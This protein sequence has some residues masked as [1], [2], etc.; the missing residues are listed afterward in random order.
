MESIETLNQRL[1]TFYGH[2]DDG[3]VKFRL[4]WSDDQIEM[5]EEVYEKYAGN[6]YLGTQFGV[7]EVPKYAYMPYQW[8]L[9]HLIPIPQINQDELLGLKLSYEP[10]WGFNNLHNRTTPPWETVKLIV[11]T[12]LDTISKGRTM[13][14]KYKESLEETNTKEG[15]AAR[16]E[17]LKKELFDGESDRASMALHLK[18]GVFIDSS[19]TFEAPTIK[20][21]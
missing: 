19:R 1:E 5:R 7:H 16:Q 11:D 6:I 13:I 12:L 4:V 10:I 15:I 9:E 14:R 2:H 17:A 3:R 18:R 21:E 20:E 8:V